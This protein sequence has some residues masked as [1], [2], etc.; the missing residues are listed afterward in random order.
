[1]I[2]QAERGI[3]VLLYFGDE[4]TLAD[5]VDSPGWDENTVARQN[6]PPQHQI[7][8]RPDVDSFF[9]LRAGEAL[10]EADANSRVRLGIDDV[11]CL[12]LAKRQAD[13]SRIG[14]VRMDLN[15]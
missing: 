1:M 14:V 13:H 9:Q 3:G 8:D 12:G 10:R 5:S 6:T 11:P 7:S 2:E 4:Q 15:G